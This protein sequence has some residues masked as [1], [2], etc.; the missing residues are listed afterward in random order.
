M[1][2]VYTKAGASLDHGTAA[3][4]DLKLRPGGDPTTRL[5]LG[6]SA[7]FQR[8]DKTIA[9]NVAT[10]FRLP[11]ASGRGGKSD[12]I[13]S[14]NVNYNNKGNGQIGARINS[15]RLPSAGSGDGGAYSKDGVGQAN[16]QGGILKRVV[17]KEFC[18]SF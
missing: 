6:A 7:V 18:S 11:K 3:S 10:E 5:L 14:G 1:G 9:G 13:V 4:A 16:H 17:Y 12:T 8:R 15:S 2:R